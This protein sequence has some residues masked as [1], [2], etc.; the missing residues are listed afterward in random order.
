MPGEQQLAKRFA[1][2]R[3]GWLYIIGLVALSMIR[4]WMLSR[5]VDRPP[6]RSSQGPPSQSGAERRNPQAHSSCGRISGG[7]SRKRKPDV[8]GNSRPHP[9]VQSAPVAGACEAEMGPL[10][11]FAGRR[12]WQWLHDGSKPNGWLEFGADAVLR[13][14]LCTGGRG[15]WQRRNNNDEMV[16]TFGKCHHIVFLL[17]EVRDQPPMFEMRER[18]M[19]DGAPVLKRGDSPT[20][21]KLDMES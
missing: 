12:R 8:A 19:K 14:S 20:R 13:T 21:G 9:E 16:I 10:W 3:Q 11:H 18:V 4:K 7:D 2:L 5:S 1:S 15:T 17:P 6:V